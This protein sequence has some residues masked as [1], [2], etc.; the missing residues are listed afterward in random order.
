MRYLPSLAW[1]SLAFILTII[2]G[3]ASAGYYV[4]LESNTLNRHVGQDSIGCYLAPTMAILSFT[5][6]RGMQNNFVTVM[7]VD[8]VA[9]TIT[10]VAWDGWVIPNAGGTLVFSYHPCTSVPA[11]NSIPAFVNGVTD[12]AFSGDSILT[13]S[14]GSGTGTASGPIT[15]TGDLQI[16]A[17]SDL[18]V[19]QASQLAIATITLWSIAWGFRVLIRTVSQSDVN[20]ED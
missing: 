13:G 4:H 11:S 5:S 10:A 6:T 1:F 20:H 15:V 7:S 16:P 19:E 2:S 8:P 14:S 17:F 18:T 12:P 3:Y 9:H